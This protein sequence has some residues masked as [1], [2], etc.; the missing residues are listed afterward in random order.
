MLRAVIALL[1][2]STNELSRFP[3]AGGVTTQLEKLK[4]QTKTLISCLRRIIAIIKLVSIELR[5]IK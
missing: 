4:V 5:I 1:E 3:V 2:N